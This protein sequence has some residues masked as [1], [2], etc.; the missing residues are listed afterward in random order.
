MRHLFEN[1]AVIFF[2]TV[3]TIGLGYSIYTSLFSTSAQKA[4][5]TEQNLVQGCQK[6]LARSIIFQN[7]AKEAA[8]ARRAQAA[9]SSANGDNVAAQ[10]NLATA[11]KYETFA[12][13]YDALTTKDCAQFYDTDK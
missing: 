9:E 10:N 8:A 3:I 4:E 11:R 13:Q 12:E 1:L 7:F 6:A 2:V 5:Q